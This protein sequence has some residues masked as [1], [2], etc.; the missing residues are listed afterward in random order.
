MDNR[1]RKITDFFYKTASNSNNKSS[2][3]GGNK[4]RPSEP[5]S[6]AEHRGSTS[7]CDSGVKEGS[8]YSR[9]G[10]HSSS[11]NTIGTNAKSSYNLNDVNLVNKISKQSHKNSITKIVPRNV[12]TALTVQ[13][14]T[15][16]I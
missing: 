2:S 3:F 14:Q 5:S 13:F 15:L 7:I 16:K 4:D 6:G 11:S 12:N 8:T 9:R 1:K 10:T